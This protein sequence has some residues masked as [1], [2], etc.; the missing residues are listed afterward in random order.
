MA[1]PKKHYENEKRLAAIALLHQITNIHVDFDSSNDSGQIENISIASSDPHFEVQKVLIRAWCNKGA[2]FNHHTKEWGVI[3][4]EEKEL[5]LL[6]FLHRH[7]KLALVGTGVDW[8]NADGGFG[9]WE[10]DP[11]KSLEFI[12]EV[13]YPE[14]TSVRIEARELGSPMSEPE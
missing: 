3:Y 6:E 1:L 10:W 5:P 9:H 7:V 11:Q 12:I 13:R 8:Y 2:V 4:S 14:M